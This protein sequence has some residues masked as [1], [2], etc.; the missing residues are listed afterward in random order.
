MTEGDN[1]V[2]K[3]LIPYI[4]DKFQLFK[5]KRTPDEDKKI[6]DKVLAHCFCELLLLLARKTG[7]ETKKSLENGLEQL[8]K[9][10][11]DQTILSEE[12]AKILSG[13]LSKAKLSDEEVLILLQKRIDQILNSAI[14]N[15]KR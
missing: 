13:Y 6:L 1:T 5:G 14:K 8:S 7:S 12:T 3:K 10:I 2:L 15:K 11:P 9:E 4:V